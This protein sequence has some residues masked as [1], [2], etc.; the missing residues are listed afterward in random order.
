[1]QRLHDEKA[2]EIS[3]LQQAI[4]TKDKALVENQRLEKELCQIQQ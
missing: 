4:T 1:M 3:K 2:Q